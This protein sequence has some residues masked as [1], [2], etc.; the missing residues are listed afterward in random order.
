MYPAYLNNDR[1]MHVMRAH[2]KAAYG[3]NFPT[4]E[5]LEESFF[6]LRASDA[7][8][9]NKAAVAKED[10]AA[11]AQR[12]D[13]IITDRKASEFDEASAY[14]MSMSDL[15]AKARGWK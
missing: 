11:I 4:I 14:T 12:A 15:E 1:N 7:L 3:V 13:Q 5:Q 2:W 6:A 10:A 9:L 8:T